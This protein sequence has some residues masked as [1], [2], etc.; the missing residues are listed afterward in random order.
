MLQA[1]TLALAISRCTVQPP[2]TLSA[3]QRALLRAAQA[4]VVEVESGGN[5]WAVGDNNASPHA[6][7]YPNSYQEAV[8]L[9]NDLVA[10][11]IAIHGRGIDLGIAQINS[12]NL[13]QHHLT[14]ESALRA[15]SNLHASSEM[16]GSLYADE[17]S[18][19][20]ATPEP[21][22]AW[23]ALDRTLRAYN[24]GS[25]DGPMSYTIS[26]ESALQDSYVQQ[27]LALLGEPSLQQEVT[28]R[29][30]RVFVPPPSSLVFGHDLGG[31]NTTGGARNSVCCP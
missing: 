26:V 28:K 22:R 17:V 20:A 3:S 11:D 15:C 18:A 29:A 1:A 16:L 13:V 14:V 21:T 12:H 8:S 27:T 4:G 2:S 23:A 6:S 25:S 31:L 9:A 30:R 10:R 5:A 19:L 7:Y 24:S